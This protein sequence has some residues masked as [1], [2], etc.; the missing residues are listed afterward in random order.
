MAP[1]VRR[2]ATPTTIHRRLPHRQSRT[3]GETRGPR[4]ASPLDGRRG[5]RGLLDGRADALVGA[6]AADIPRHRGVDVG[7]SGVRLLRQERCSRH[8]LARLAVA[9]LDDLEIEPRLVA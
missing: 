5:V 8:D 1:P 9:A 7:V 6:A 3:P 2:Y 4:T